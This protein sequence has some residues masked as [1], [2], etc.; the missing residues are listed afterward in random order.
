[1]AILLPKH[2]LKSYSIFKGDI[3][4]GW[5]FQG[6]INAPLYSTQHR[7]D[8]PN[9][10]HTP[11]SSV[12]R[13]ADEREHLSEDERMLP[14]RPGWC[15]K[16]AQC[17]CGTQ[18]ILQKLFLELLFWKMR[19]GSLPVWCQPLAMLLYSALGQRH[20]LL[21]QPVSAVQYLCSNSSLVP[22]PRAVTA[23]VSFGRASGVDVVCSWS[24]SPHLPHSV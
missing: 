6:E 3:H 2:L 9:S 21:F 14:S 16:A 19:K 12:E 24:S 17:L 20:F 8:A 18:P 13:R 1:M 11:I 23:P 15:S 22:P 5:Y 10:S 7:I 4:C